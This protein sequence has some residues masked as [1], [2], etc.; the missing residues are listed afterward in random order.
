MKKRVFVQSL[1]ILLPVLAV[2]LATTQNSVTVFDTVSGQT[3]YFSYFDILPVSNLQMITPLTALCSVASGILAAIYMAKKKPALLKASGYAAIA[4]VCLVAIPTV[5][6]ETVMV[7]PN[8]GLPI[9]M[10]IH[11]ICCSMLPKLEAAE[12]PQKTKHKRL[13]NR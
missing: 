5:M 4:S 7:I 12:Q 13:P 9:F 6:R 3:R 1:L 2:G 11:F 8:V 10:V